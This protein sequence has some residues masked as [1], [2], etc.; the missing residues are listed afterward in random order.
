LRDQLTNQVH[1]LAIEEQVSFLGYQEDVYSVMK[2]CDLL[3]LPSF[4]EGMALVIF[5]ALGAGIP[6]V[7]SRIPALESWFKD[8]EIVSLFDP[9]SL[10]EITA[11]IS[12]ELQRPDAQ[13]V[14]RRLAA[15]RLVTGLDIDVMVGKYTDLYFDLLQ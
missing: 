3:V 14:Q 9:Y 11:C 10:D 6:V 15:D 12:R 5:E 1:N 4:R 7:A 13:K 8:Q 2:A